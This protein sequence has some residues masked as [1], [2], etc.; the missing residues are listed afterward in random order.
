VVSTLQRVPTPRHQTVSESEN[1]EMNLPT[2]TSKPVEGI[3]YPRKTTGDIQPAAPMYEETRPKSKTMYEELKNG[4][5]PEK[6]V[7]ADPNRSPSKFTPLLNRSQR[8]DSFKGSFQLKLISS[9]H[10]EHQTPM[11]DSIIRREST[12]VHEESPNENEVQINVIIPPKNENNQF[13]QGIID[14]FFENQEDQKKSL[15]TLMKVLSV[16]TWLTKED[17]KKLQYLFENVILARQ[18]FNL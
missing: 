3:D 11:R 12:P 16:C 15:E 5:T 2:E 6:R 9:D 7:A 13:T 8:A 14:R 4:I 17:R 1:S 10:P 18:F